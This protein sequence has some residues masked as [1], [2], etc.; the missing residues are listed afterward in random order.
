VIPTRN[1]L[2]VGEVTTCNSV[3]SVAAVYTTLQG[4]L[5]DPALTRPASPR[6]HYACLR[7][8][9]APPRS[10]FLQRPTV[11]GLTGKANQLLAR[12]VCVRRAPLNRLMHAPTL[13]SSAYTPVSEQ[14]A[15]KFT[16]ALFNVTIYDP[17]IM[18]AVII[19]LG[20]II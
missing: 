7:W 16:P 12:S 2:A 1:S 5:Y 19:T 13:G 8:K 11:G 3:P 10:L 20:E 6:A 4:D 14:L 15:A 17:L 9:R 18:I